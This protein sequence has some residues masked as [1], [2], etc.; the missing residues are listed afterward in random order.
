MVGL[1]I[2]AIGIAPLFGMG[3]FR[4]SEGFSHAEFRI[5]RYMMGASF[6]YGFAP[7]MLAIVFDNFGYVVGYAGLIPVAIACY[8]LWKI[9][10]KH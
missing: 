5:S 6:C 3:A 2:S 1:T 10:G 7:F 9:N 8:L 4:V